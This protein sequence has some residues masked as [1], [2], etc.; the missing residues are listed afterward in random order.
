MLNKTTLVPCPVD[1]RVHVETTADSIHSV[2]T[3]HIRVWRAEEPNPASRLTKTRQSDVSFLSSSIHKTLPGRNCL[4]ESLLEA[5]FTSVV[6]VAPS[7]AVVVSDKGQLCLVDDSDGTQRFV[8]VADIGVTVTSMAVD[9]KGRLHLASSQ[10][11]LKT[12]HL[13]NVVSILTPPPSPPARLEPPTILLTPDASKVEAVGA[14]LDYLVT[15]DSQNSIR[16]SNLC[17][18][19]NEDT[20]GDVVQILPA[21]GDPVLGV[22]SLPRANATGASFYTWS[23]GGTI[24]FWTPEGTHKETLEVPLEQIDDLDV[25]SNELKAVVS[26]ADADFIMTGDRYGVLR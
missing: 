11:D 18:P 1:N 10:G 7:K 20:L 9:S 25:G 4:L 23:T 5:N 17:A 2:G 13:A 6:A 22:A 15:V 3:R 21:H 19:D 14:L 26:S 8:K 12:L 24:L 16:L